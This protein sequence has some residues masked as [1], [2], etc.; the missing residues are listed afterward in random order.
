MSVGPFLIPVVAIIGAFAIVITS[1]I[2]QSKARDRR[3]R[4]RMLMAEK[5]LE[6][7]QELYEVKEVKRRDFR[8][9]RAWLMILGTICICV[10]IG[11][12]IMLGVQKGIDE[13]IA[14]IIPIFIGAGF[15]ASERMI[16]RLADK[17][18][19]K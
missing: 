8:G 4:E 18:R 3:Q 6:I 2:L 7:P 10:G 11:V 12:M 1:M 13:G 15:L 19:D 17:D 5:G 14:G 16:A 9:G